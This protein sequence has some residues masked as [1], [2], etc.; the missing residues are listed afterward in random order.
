MKKR[1]ICIITGSRAEWGLLYP[2]AKEIKREKVKFKLQIIATGGH[3][4]RNYGSTF[5]EIE[6]D[7]FNIDKKIRLP[8]KVDT[9]RAVGEAVSVGTK[10][11]V[12]AFEELLPD[13]VCLLG[14]R[15]EIFSAASAAVF[16]KIPI[17]HI[18]GGELTEGSIDDI[19]R[20]AITK[21]SQLHFTSTEA[22]RKR[23]IQMGENP[24]NVFNVGAIGLDNI[25]NTRLLERKVFEQKTN[26]K[27]GRKNVLVTFNPPT[28]EDKNLYL[29]QFRNLLKALDRLKDTKVV[30]TKPNPDMYSSKIADLIDSYTRKRA[31]RS[32]AFTSMGRELYLSALNLVD[33]VAGNSSSA[34]IEVPS[35]GIP[36]IN[37]GD[38]QKGR[39]KSRSVIDSDGSY[40]SIVKAFEKTVNTDFRNKCKKIK[41]IYGDGMAAQKI[42]KVLR[43]M[44]PCGIRKN[45]HDIDL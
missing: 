40:G 20:H 35:F 42:T 16:M 10:G 30:F 1:K 37:I 21:M 12:L 13:L 18:H 41:N 6:R 33:V 27:L 24:L 11:F 2:L 31:D 23:V 9:P 28:A 22:Y 36:S 4:S 17:A 5:R 39:I 25:K 44:K 14:D 32:K 38:R 43:K 3:L 29:G 45:F 34:I 7:G 19:L 26:F 15:F 8:L